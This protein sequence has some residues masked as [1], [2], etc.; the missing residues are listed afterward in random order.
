MSGSHQP[1]TSSSVIALLSFFFIGS[2]SIASGFHAAHYVL[3]SGMGQTYH[4]RLPVLGLRHVPGGLEALMSRRDFLKAAAVVGA[5]AM[6]GGVARS[7]LAQEQRAPTSATKR[8]IR[9]LM[10][11]YGP[12]STGFSLAMKR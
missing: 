10:G 9:I 7:A 2:S 1:V 12:A 11:G 3:Q 5:A 6:A 4:G 8:P